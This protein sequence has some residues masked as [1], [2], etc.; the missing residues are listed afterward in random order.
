L[1]LQ[2]DGLGCGFLLYVTNSFL[3]NVRHSLVCVECT[4][5][6][7]IR[8]QIH[9]LNYLLT[10]LLT[11]LITYLP[12]YLLTYLPTYLLTYLPTYLL[13]YLITYSLT[14]SLT[15][16]LTHSLTHPLTHS[17]TPWSRVLYEKLT[18]LQLVKKLPAFYGTRR[19][20]TA[21]TSARQL[22]PS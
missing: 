18:A 9:L 2:N 7:I 6:L 20:I 8:S 19:F 1:V 13:N 12:T 21:F 11:Y 16:P 5:F 4:L 10:Y 15:Y 22:Y 17:L 3:W 14:H